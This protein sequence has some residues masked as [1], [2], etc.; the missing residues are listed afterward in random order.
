MN[1][2]GVDWKSHIHPHGEETFFYSHNGELLFEDDGERGPPAEGGDDE[3]ARP[4]LDRYVLRQLIHDAVQPGTIKWNHGIASVQVTATNQY[5][6]TFLDGSS[7]V[8]DVLVGADGAHSRIRPLLSPHKA[9]YAGLHG[10]E[11]SVTTETMT[12]PD[13]LP[14]RKGALPI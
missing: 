1:E 5:Q 6:L 4:E 12:L 7:S 3:N 14:L 8:C 10:A 2:L 9:E 13:M 11:I